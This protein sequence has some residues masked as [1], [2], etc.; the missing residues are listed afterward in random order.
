MARTLGA[1]MVCFPEQPGLHPATEPCWL[2]DWLL[3]S[4]RYRLNTSDVW[5]AEILHAPSSTAYPSWPARAR[6]PRNKRDSFFVSPEPKLARLFCTSRARVRL[7]HIQLIV[8]QDINMH[9]NG[10]KLEQ[11]CTRVL[12]YHWHC[13]HQLK[14]NDTLFCNDF[15]VH[16]CFCHILFAYS[17]LDDI[18]FPSYRWIL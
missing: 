3:K 13:W 17:C 18:L 15:Y 9:H 14:I 16:K 8:C 11:Q 1:R 5:L 12:Q 7:C 4:P 6:L 2:V 10:L